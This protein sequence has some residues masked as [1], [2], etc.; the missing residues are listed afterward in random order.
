LAANTLQAPTEKGDMKKLLVTLA[1]TIVV[2]LGVSWG[3]KMLMTDTASYD[4]KFTS[5][6][7]V[8]KS[9]IP[10]PHRHFQSIHYQEMM[11]DCER[12]ANVS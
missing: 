6:M 4:E 8:K 12:Q 11:R 1:V 5:C 3:Y 2:A 10:V 9:W 7:E